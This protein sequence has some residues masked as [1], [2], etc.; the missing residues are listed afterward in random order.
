MSLRYDWIFENRASLPVVPSSKP[1]YCLGAGIGA[2]CAG[3][4]TS[5][6]VRAQMSATT[7]RRVLRCKDLPP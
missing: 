6:A 7:D 2:A 4:A 5:M 3:A 1:K